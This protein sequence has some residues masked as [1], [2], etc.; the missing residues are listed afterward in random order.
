MFLEG[1]PAKERFVSLSASADVVPVCRQVLADYQTPVSLLARFYDRRDGVFL[2]ESVEGG[3]RWGRFSFLGISSRAKI[4]VYQDH[5]FIRECGNE[6]RIP[7]QGDPMQ[8]LREIMA[9]YRPADLPELPRFYGGLVGYFSYE[10]VSF[11]EKIPHRLDATEPLAQFVI[12]DTL[13]IVDNVRHTLTVCVLTFPNRDEAPPETLYENAMQQIDTVIEKMHQ[14]S[15]L[16]VRPAPQEFSLRSIITEEEFRSRVRRVKEQIVEGEIIQAVI[17]QPFVSDIVPDPISLYRAQRY[18]N[19]SP[20]MYFM[21]LGE[22]V[23]VGSSP[24]TMVRLEGNT[25]CVRPIAGT[26]PRGKTEQEDRALADELLR[27]EKEKAEHLMLVDLGRNDLGRIA[28]TNTVQVTDL[29]VVE[30]YSHVMHLVSNVICEMQDQ[31]DALDLFRATFPAGTLS[32]A[33]KVRA[34]E[35]ISEVE[36]VPRGPYG[37]AAGYISFNGNMDFAIVIRTACIHR[38][39]LFAQAGAGIVFDSDPERERHESVNKAMSIQRALELL[40]YIG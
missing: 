1:F 10:A 4:E 12:P 24:E 27:D 40:K 29:M 39:R 6:E 5:V 2:L 21:H 20:Y 17:S 28:H 38:K 26:R 37:G 15:E 7:H 9:K 33:P 32:G 25:A 14:Q 3:E 36:E 23:L 31:Y 18:V 16:P 35:I 11:F 19:P 30:R 8:V 13:L 34:M 22:T